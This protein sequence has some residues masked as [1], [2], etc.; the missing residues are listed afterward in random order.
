MTDD[1]Q[2]DEAQAEAFLRAIGG[3]DWRAKTF[4]FQIIDERDGERPTEIRTG[5]WH[6]LKDWLKFNNLRGYGVFIEYNG[7]TG[8]GGT[9]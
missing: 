3:P 9:A 5:R 7:T 2:I 4:N 8:I 6:D 1:R